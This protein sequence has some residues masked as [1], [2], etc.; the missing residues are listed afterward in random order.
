MRSALY[1]GTVMH[2]RR[3][4]VENVFRYP[5]YMTLL[6][7][8]ELPRLD[9]EL[10][11]FGWNRRALTSYH[12]RDHLDVRAHLAAAGVEL[13]EGG[14]LEVLTNLR[15][16]G[17]VFNPVSFWWC[18]R[19]DGELACIVA[20][21][22]NTFGERLPY[23]L[24]PAEADGVAGARRVWHTDKRL[25]VSPFMPMDQ[26]Y[27]WWLS[28]PGPRVGVRM[29]VHEEGRPDFQA[30]LVARRVE[31]T[32]SS[33]RAALIRYPLMPATVLARI[34]LQAARLWTK[35]V[36][37]FPKPPFVPGRGTTRP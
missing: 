19:G 3:A 31:L 22:A 21:V 4:P 16:L 10:P 20:E 9:R 13:G 29:D 7:L 1:V 35:R 12:D 27:T 32:A 23:L 5:V 18:Y 15:V 26:S 8:D 17:H 37:F 28:A 34:H 14:R 36:P 25:H 6:D 11:L 24:L 30:T 2:A 33:L